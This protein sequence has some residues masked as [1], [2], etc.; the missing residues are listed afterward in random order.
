MNPENTISTSNHWRKSIFYTLTV[1]SIW[2]TASFGCAILFRDWCDANLPK[3]GNVPFGFWMSQQ[4]AILVFLGLLFA[5]SAL[6]NRL[7][8]SLEQ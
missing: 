2:F 4:G 3:I 5:Y 1:L 7:D 6:M 8:N